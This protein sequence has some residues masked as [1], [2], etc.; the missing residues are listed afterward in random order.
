MSRLATVRHDGVVCIVDP[1]KGRETALTPP[2]A[3]FS[4]PTWSPDGTRLVA[5]GFRSGSNGHG[6]L[7]LYLLPP[8]GGEPRPIFLNERGADAIALGTPHYCLWSPNGE[9]VAFIAQ[10]LAGLGLYVIDLSDDEGPQRL[11]P[12]GPIYLAWSPGSRFLLVHSGASHYLVDLDGDREAVRMPGEA[13]ASLYMSPSWS[14]RADLM[15]MFRSLGRD[16]QALVVA[17]A[18]DGTAQVLTEVEG[19][20]A[21]A[22][23]P[24]GNAMA[25]ARGLDRRAGFYSGLWLVGTDGSGERQVC[26]DPLLSFAWSPDGSRIAYVTRSQDAEGSIR[27]AVVDV[28]TGGVARLADFRPSQ[29]QLTTFMFFDQYVMSHSPWSPDGDSLLFSGVLGYERVRR[30]L[31]AGRSTQ[32]FAADARGDEPPRPVAR[33]LAGFWRPA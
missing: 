27:W 14:P 31:P 8:E 2:G 22:W 24:D 26:D 29:E 3:A 17:N 16:H 12:G 5:S 28:E 21:F 6:L 23:R 10:S 7:G 32:V 13:R 19:A 25:M 1:G 15:A 33:G 20:A 18:V 9:R 4:W 11:L 30:P